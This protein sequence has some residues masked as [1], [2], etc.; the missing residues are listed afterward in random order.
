MT[1]AMLIS[2]F[3]HSQVFIKLVVKKAPL[4]M[5]AMNASEWTAMENTMVV[6]IT[7]TKPEPGDAEIQ[8]NVSS[9]AMLLKLV[10]KKALVINHKA[11][12]H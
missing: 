9:F 8:R 7:A 12:L 1:L 5:F 4:R 6:T 2:S 3:Q 11:I 10:N